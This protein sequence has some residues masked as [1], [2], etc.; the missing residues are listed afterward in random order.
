MCFLAYRENKLADPPEQTFVGT[1]YAEYKDRIESD[2]NNQSEPSPVIP[3]GDVNPNFDS[4]NVFSSFSSS[5]PIVDG[6][7]YSPIRIVVE[8]REP[9]TFPVDSSRSL[10]ANAV[11]ETDQLFAQ[12]YTTP[13]PVEV[14]PAFSSNPDLFS[15]GSFIPFTS[16]PD[17]LVDYVQEDSSSLAPLSNDSS[18]FEQYSNNIDTLRDDSSVSLSN[19]DN[20]LLTDSDMESLRIPDS[21][22][23]INPEDLLSP[24]PPLMN[25]DM[26]LD[27]GV[28]F[29]HPTTGFT[30]NQSLSPWD[31]RTGEEENQS[32]GA[33]VSGI[34]T[35]GP[36]E[37]E[38]GGEGEGE[39]EGGGEGEEGQEEKEEKKKKKKKKNQS[40]RHR[41]NFPGTGERI[42]I[43]QWISRL[44]GGPNLKESA[45]ALYKKYYRQRS[46]ACGS[47][48]YV[49]VAEL[50]MIVKI[51]I[52]RKARHLYFSYYSMKKNPD[53]YGIQL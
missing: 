49:F 32:G 29:P 42:L 41:L 13:S 8:D 48:V 50:G 25:V 20:T 40:V 53:H 2:Q 26:E 4:P 17:R 19:R 6:T 51:T 38:G 33:P 7:F 14:L 37:R 35:Q 18:H 30:P 10:P 16:E 3:P 9:S 1:T 46:M 39:G 52:G 28:D 15:F 24:Q 23:S 45:K 34:I 22:G 31:P 47:Q 11:F 5:Q 27:R 12:S 21:T 36:E 43:M 44:I